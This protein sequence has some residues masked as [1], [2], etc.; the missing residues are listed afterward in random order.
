M[1]YLNFSIL[2]A[3][4][5]VVIITC[6]QSPTSV[7]KLDENQ[8]ILKM[9]SLPESTLTNIFIDSHIKFYDTVY[10]GSDI[11]GYFSIKNIGKNNLLISSIQSGCNCIKIDNYNDVVEAIIQPGDSVLLNFTV[12]FVQEE[13][14]LS[15]GL[16]IIGNFH[17]YYRRILIEAYVKQ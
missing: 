5:S 11:T 17:P 4:L 1:K 8:Y 14:Y 13:G 10:L 3:I 7:Q 12:P 9:K 16:T 6:N 2:L 15:K